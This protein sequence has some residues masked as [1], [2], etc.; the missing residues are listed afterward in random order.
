MSDE[1]R[2]APNDEPGMA[3]VVVD[4]SGEGQRMV[5]WVDHGS[6]ISPWLVR[7]TIQRALEAGWTPKK[8][9]PEL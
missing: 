8:R 2:V 6:I 5:T 3:I 1:R 7:L 4:G 9:G